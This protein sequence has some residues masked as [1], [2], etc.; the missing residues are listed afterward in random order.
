MLMPFLNGDAKEISA[1][2]LKI[3]KAREL[4]AFLQRPDV[5]FVRLVRCDRPKSGTAE[6]VIFQV[7]VE[8]GQKTIHDIRR[9]E[10][11]GVVFDPTDKLAPEVLALR[12]D[13]PVVPHQNLRPFDRPRSLCLDEE[14]YS[15]LKLRWTA[16]TFVERIREW[17]RLTA[18]GQLHQNDQPLEPLL[19]GV[20]GTMILPHD[21]VE[22][23][24]AQKPS[25]IAIQLLNDSK[26]RPVYRLH[27]K[28]TDDDGKKP[29][30][31]ATVFTTPP[32]EHGIIH[33]QPTNL[34]ELHE[35]CRKAN[36]DLLGE[37]NARLRDWIVQ[38]SA[39]DINDARFVLV[40][41]FPKKRQA[42]AS[43]E[44]PDVWVFCSLDTVHQIAVALGVE[45]EKKIGGFA[46]VIVNV[47]KNKKTEDLSPAKK[48]GIFPLRPVYTLTPARAAVYNGFN[49]PST[50][51]IIAVGMGALGSQIFNNMMRSGFGEWTLIDKDI[52]LPHNCARHALPGNAAGLNKADVLAFMANTTIEGTSLTR[53]IPTDVFEPGDKKD[54]LNKAFADADVILD[55]SASVAVARHLAN[56][57]DAKARR[58]SIF[59][60]PSGTD[61][62]VLA[63][64]AARKV[65]LVWLEMEYYRRL[66]NENDLS[67]H[68]TGDGGRVRYARSCGDITS[69]ISQN[70]VALHAAIGSQ[71]LRN[72]LE[73]KTASIKIFRAAP[74]SFA[75]HNF[76]FEPAQ[77]IIKKTSDWRVCVSEGVFAKVHNLRKE[78]L[79]NETGGILIGN[80]DRQQRVI[81]IV[82]ALGSPKDSAEWP[83][84][85]IRGVRGLRA[86]LERIGKA[87]LTNLEYVGEWHSHPPGCAAKPSSTDQRAITTLAAQM[88]LEGLPAMMLIV[89][90]RGCHQLFIT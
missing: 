45:A 74:D 44:Y 1:A 21:F 56:G 10:F 40:A 6:A 3:P 69:R 61:L 53:S 51:R 58:V 38:K 39:A 64:D 7:E 4:V 13:F 11:I 77:A 16:L 41:V 85:Y 8:L 23:A 35:F 33:T 46:G 15:E 37:L 68:L 57:V 63:E 18:R 88:S 83:T 2:K 14:P 55:F 80:F 52:L 71:N 79:P 27:L 49:E 43:V 50:K 70:L 48:V 84:L 76:D 28:R 89:A 20:E 72:V 31:I 62:V 5:P 87:T 65:P 34:Y 47:V 30:V 54:E 66:A 29:R 9:D 32:I 90:E 22:Q 82:D 24:N 75:V 26:D 78:R 25:V 36:Y 19:S 60:N 81:Y 12:E 86:E 17:L 67:G 59:L 73:Q 42:N